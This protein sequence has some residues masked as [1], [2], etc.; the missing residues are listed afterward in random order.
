MMPSPRR[1]AVTCLLTAGLLTTALSSQQL[2]PVHRINRTF[3]TS[4]WTANPP[5]YTG[6]GQTVPAGTMHWRAFLEQ[7][8]QRAEPRQ[9]TAIGCWWQPSDLTGSFPQ[10]INTLE[11]R[12]YPT[13][14]DPQGLVI[15]DTGQPPALVVPPM[16]M[17]VNQGSAFNELTVSLGAAVPLQIQGDYAVCALY[18]TGAS[19]ALPGFFGLLP[20]GANNTY[21]LGQSLF[22]SLYAGGATTHFALGGAR[23]S[24]WL[25]ENQP[26]ISIRGNWALSASHYASGYLT[27]AWGDSSY[28]TP[29]ADPSWAGWTDG[30]A[31]ATMGLTIHAQ[32]MEGFFP[33]LLFNAGLRFPTGFPFLGLTLE[34]LPADPLFVALSPMGQPIQN[35]R[36]DLTLPLL[37]VAD[38]ALAGSYFGFEAVLVDTTN[39]VLADSTQSVWMRH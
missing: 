28:F 3:Y 6:A 16:P 32:G 25:T 11:Y 27:G 36:Y 37:S 26:T 34:L 2:N 18:P 17:P 12:I 33:I 9:L 1:A 13:T 15:P 24:L 30:R 4:M 23:S 38:P 22:G 5:E 7:T 21:G 29:L 35:G 39:L 8:N 20:S 31:P 10:T 14:T 19:A